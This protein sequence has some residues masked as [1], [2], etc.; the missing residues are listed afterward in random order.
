MTEIN[1]TPEAQVIADL[2]REATVPTIVKDPDSH[3]RWLAS[4]QGGGIYLTELSDP[5]EATPGR[6][7]ASLRLSDADSL[8]QYCNRF[9][10]DRGVF[11]ATHHT[12]TI[13]AELDF[14]GES[15]SRSVEGQPTPDRHPPVPA[16]REHHA[17]L[18]LELSEEWQIWNGVDG[19]MMDQLEFA[20]FLE[21]NSIDVAEPSG[22]DL[23]EI[24]RD[25]HAVR[26][27]N[28]R[29]IVRTQSGVEKIEY[30]D[31][32]KPAGSVEIPASFTLKIPVYFGEPAIEIT[33]ALRWKNTGD[34]L[35]LGI[36]LIRKE[37]HRQAEFKRI[38][39][40]VSG[41]A[42]YPLFMGS[43]GR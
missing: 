26:A 34:S 32:N 19:R 43:A 29:S 33:A 14:Y 31:E 25:F 15:V 17:I 35:A 12:H 2:A 21:E 5:H 13:A 22:A 23:I 36:K 18:T 9:G 27:Q 30:S 1:T 41:E 3:R 28:F 6:V 39:Q 42:G 7:V 20:R 11:F 8:V 16:F 40:A 4:G 37:N 38:A 24:C 10:S